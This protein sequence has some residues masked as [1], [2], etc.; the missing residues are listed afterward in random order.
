LYL[1]LSK[2]IKLEAGR[3][4]IAPINVKPHSPTPPGHRWGFVPPLL[5]SSAPQVRPCNCV[6]NSVD[7]NP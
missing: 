2:I 7:G 5:E 4:D 1:F 6:K 3:D